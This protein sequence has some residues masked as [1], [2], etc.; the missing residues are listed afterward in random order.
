MSRKLTSHDDIVR[1]IERHKLG[2]SSSQIA[3]AVGI[4][5]RTVRNLVRKF[6]E[7]GNHD[8]PRHTH[9][10]G[11]SKK[12]SPR[13]LKVLKRQLDKNPTL[14]ARK[15]KEDNPQLLGETSVRT[16]QRRLS[17]DLGYSKV[18]AKRKPLITATQKKN[19]VAF[20]KKY[21]SWDLEK[22]RK[23]MWTDESTFFTSDPSGTKVWKRKGDDPV[24]PNLTLKT[25][26]FPPFLYGMGCVWA[27][28][29]V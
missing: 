5:P 12:Q 16:I 17:Q 24:N 4:K 22:W 29:C 27:R 6:V 1:I 9:G 26:K 7:G 23:V 2:E 3:A 13:T 11:T 14:T 21:A 19:C 10:G 15:L 18:S 8:L 28:W 20:A 25:V